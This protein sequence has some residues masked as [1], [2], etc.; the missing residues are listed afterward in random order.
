MIVD[1][2]DRERRTRLRRAESLMCLAVP[3]RI[4]SIDGYT[5][6]CEARGIRREVSLFM[7][8]DEPLAPGDH[9]LVHVGYA[10]QKI[11]AAEAS[12][13]WKLFDE[14]LDAGGGITEH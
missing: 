5:C 6:T 10:I 14:I 12:E 9:V 11:T 2:D 13:S 7:L 4:Q 3:M 8:Q 1:T